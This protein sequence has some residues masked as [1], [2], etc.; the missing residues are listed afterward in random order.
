M[1]V[2]Q[3]SLPQS[4]FL[5]EGRLCCLGLRYGPYTCPLFRA[6]NT[7]WLEGLGIQKGWLSGCPHF[8]G[9][10]AWGALQHLNATLGFSGP[11]SD[12]YYKCALA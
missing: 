6:G 12:P 11:A 1:H 5:Q 2:R 10:Y 8:P 9:N 7:G 4:S 3:G